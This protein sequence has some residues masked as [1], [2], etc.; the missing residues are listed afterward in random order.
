MNFEEHALAFPCA[1]SWLYGILTL[2]EQP[3]RRGV[4]IIVGGPQYRAGSHRQ[5]TLLARNLAAHGFA[6][7]RFDFRGMGDSE[8][9][10][11]TFEAVEDDLRCAIDK[12]FLEAPLIDELVIWGLCDAAS[13][14]IFYAYQDRR[15]TGLVLLNPWVRTE[16]GSAKAYLRHYYASRLFEREFWTKIVQGK[17]Q[18]AAAAQSFAKIITEACRAKR[19]NY[20]S[21]GKEKRT[22][23]EIAPLPD[24]MF[25]ELNLF[26]GKVLL[27]LSGNDLT[28]QEFSDLVKDSRKWEKLMAAPRVM[29]RD[30][31]G[32]NH[33]FSRREWRDQV[34]T[35]TKDWISSW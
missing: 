31:P 6:V 30:L 3:I 28:A 8:G 33:T 35:W 34:M 21:A 27:I 5:F 9:E 11:R 1:D 10:T 29:C 17:F 4:L 12:F 18:L 24:R 19:G 23:C 7:M 2:P 32:A 25:Q 22:S 20:A 26:K 16:E 13:A 14:A 15:V